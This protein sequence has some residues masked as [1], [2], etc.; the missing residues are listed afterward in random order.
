VLHESD[1]L[2]LERKA[3]AP[4]KILLIH[5]FFQKYGGQDS[6]VSAEIKGLATR[7][8]KVIPFTRHS[9]ELYSIGLMAKLTFPIDAIFS[10]QTQRELLH[11]I[12]T[13][14]PDVAYI[15]NVFPLL[16]PSVYHTLSIA[17]VPC[18]QCVHD[19]RLLC[20]NGLFYVDGK[21]CE[22][23]KG[24]NYGHAVIH[25]CFRASRVHSAVYAMSLGLNRM[26]GMLDKID[27]FLCLNP[28][29]V[30]KLVEAGIPRNKLFIRPNSLDMATIHPDTWDGA[31]DYAV[32]AGRLSPEKGLLTL[33]DAFAR[34]KPFRLKILGTG[35]MEAELEQRIKACSLD[36]V[37]LLGFRDGEEK[38]Q[39]L[40]GARFGIIPSEWYENFPVVAL[41]LFGAGKPIIASRIG[42]LPSIV[43][44]GETGLL[45]EAGNIS[46]LTD[47]ARFL[48]DHP[49]KAMEWGRKARSRGESRYGSQGCSQ[50]LFEILETVRNRGRVSTGALTASHSQEATFSSECESGATRETASE[51]ITRSGVQ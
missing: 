37:E 49:E 29:Y 13:E 34:L 10:T 46:D 7:G 51:V 43:S 35:P 45:F 48:I 40:R 25:R 41:E 36:N 39:V 26:A 16:S 30:D 4:L 2:G 19:F 12:S 22:R 47:R 23:C 3:G 27:G 17:G 32:Y 11:V 14:K 1:P 42:G 5:N 8:H 21:C 18:L 20:P 15:H 24:G 31:R 28:F 33:L 44:D 38:W 9:N 50:E 6:V